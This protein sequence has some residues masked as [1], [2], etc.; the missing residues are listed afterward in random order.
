MQA[1]KYISLDAKHKTFWCTKSHPQVLIPQTWAMKSMLELWY[2]IQ[3]SV[4]IVIWHH[5]TDVWQLYKK[6][7]FI[8]WPVTCPLSLHYFFYCQKFSR[9]SL[10]PELFIA[11]TDFWARIF[12]SSQSKV[13]FKNH[14][15]VSRQ[16]NKNHFHVEKYVHILLPSDNR[17][18]EKSI[19]Y[20]Q[21]SSFNWF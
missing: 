21:L 10:S 18:V 12:H 4:R 14:N 7:Y 11:N 2:S 6:W 1:H 13:L 15:T 8:K 16:Q 19:K 17:V 20:A 3:L 5:I 9:L